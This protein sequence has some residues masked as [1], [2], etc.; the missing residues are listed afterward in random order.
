M[1]IKPIKTNDGY[2]QSLKIVEPYLDK[3]EK[4]TE[5]LFWFNARSSNYLL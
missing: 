3:A 1:Q 2:L 4:L 5:I